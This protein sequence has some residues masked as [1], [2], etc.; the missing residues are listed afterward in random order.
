MQPC[1]KP[2]KLEDLLV[3]KQI[4]KEMVDVL[5]L[6]DFPMVLPQGHSIHWYNK[7]GQDSDLP[8]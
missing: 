6:G 5:S 4:T 3:P 8:E 7:E 1:W 2:A